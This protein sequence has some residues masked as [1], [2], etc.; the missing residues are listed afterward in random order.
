MPSRCALSAE[1]TNSS[2][3]SSSNTV[4]KN[5]VP[6]AETLRP[7]IVRRCSCTARRSSLMSANL[8]ICVEQR[9]ISPLKICVG[10][11]IC[12]PLR[13]T[14]PLRLRSLTVHSPASLRMSTAWT[15]ATS[16]KGSVMSALRAR[17]I[18]HSQCSRG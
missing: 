16:A 17:P 4:R 11:A 8:S 15:L 14:P 1:D 5:S 10:S 2:A 6:P 9:R 12:S 18:R 3:S 13:N 7:A